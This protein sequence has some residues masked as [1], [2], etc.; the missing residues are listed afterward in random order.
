MLVAAGC[1]GVGS[2]GLADGDADAAAASTLVGRRQLLPAG[3]RRRARRRRCRVGDRPHAAGH[4]AAR[5]RAHARRPRGDRRGRR[6]GVPGRRVP[7]GRRGRGRGRGHGYDRGCPRGRRA[8]RPTLPERAPPTRTCGWIPPCSRRSSTASPR[9]S[10]RPGPST[11]R[12]FL[13]NAGPCA[14]IWRRSIGEFRRGLAA[15]DSR[16]MITNHAAFGYLAAAYGLQQEAIS[17]LSPE[18]EPDAARIA[19][20]AADACGR[21]GHDGLHRDLV[22]PKV[23]ETL[24][25]EAGLDDR[26]PQPAGRPHATSRSPPATTTCP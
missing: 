4:R 7:A 16:V 8:R 6:R 9:R 24:A 2:G 18:A 21:R 23:A 13:A 14:R 25:A 15:C 20:L 11:P 12:R 22:S 3:L 10:A 26:G 5:P 1:A 19:E 17:G